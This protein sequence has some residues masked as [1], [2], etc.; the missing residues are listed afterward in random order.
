[1]TWV[2]SWLWVMSSAPSLL[3]EALLAVERR[4]IASSKAA[5]R[6]V[7]TYTSPYLMSH[8]VPYGVSN[9]GSDAMIGSSNKSISL[10]TL[11]HHGAK[12]WAVVSGTRSVMSTRLECLRGAQSSDVW[13]WCADISSGRATSRAASICAL[14][15]T[16][17]SLPEQHIAGGLYVR[18]VSWFGRTY[19]CKLTNNLD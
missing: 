2:S 11:G 15:S 5:M 14:G 4:Y 9:V 18:R 19:L 3:F 17:S 12:L 8:T 1:M 7:S 6:A 13:F 16:H 10:L